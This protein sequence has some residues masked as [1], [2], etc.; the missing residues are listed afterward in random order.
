VSA[1]HLEERE[2]L[3][4]FSLEARFPDDYEGDQDGHAWVQGWEAQ[5]KP[6]VVRAVLHALKERPGWRHHVRNRGAAPEDEIE[7]VVEK[8]VG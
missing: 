8:V 4:R 2:F 5:V 1:S 7:V 6:A 3:L